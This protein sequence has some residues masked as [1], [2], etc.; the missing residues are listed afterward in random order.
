MLAEVVTWA[1]QSR[2][3]AAQRNLGARAGNQ[4]MSVRQ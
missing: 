2:V 4:L 1:G 3:E